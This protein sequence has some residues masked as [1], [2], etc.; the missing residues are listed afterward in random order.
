MLIKKLIY[1]SIQ[2]IVLRKV[3]NK[4]VLLHFSDSSSFCVELKI[5]IIV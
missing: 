3:T 2:K 5:K 1:F 4:I